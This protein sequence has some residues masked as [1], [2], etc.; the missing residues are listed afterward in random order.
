MLKS[1]KISTNAE[2]NPEWS[3]TGHEIQIP[4]SLRGNCHLLERQQDPCNRAAWIKHYLCHL[5]KSDQTQVILQML[6]SLS[7][8]ITLVLPM[9]ENQAKQNS[10][11]LLT[12][13]LTVCFEKA[14]PYIAA[15]VLEIWYGVFLENFIAFFQFFI[16]SGME[17]NSSH[18]HITNQVF[19]R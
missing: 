5:G 4:L 17:K 13:K 18:W 6:S 14:S 3:R 8:V 9:T 10:L 11:R 15:R 2:R 12:W 16:Q 19:S 7:V 1:S